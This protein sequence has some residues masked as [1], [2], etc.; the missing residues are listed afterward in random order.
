M[1]FLKK[2]NGVGGLKDKMLLV[3]IHS[4]LHLIDLKKSYSYNEVVGI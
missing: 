1:V 2:G 3:M 4:K